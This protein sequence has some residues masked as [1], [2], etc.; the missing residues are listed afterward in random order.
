MTGAYRNPQLLASSHRVEEF[1][2]RSSEQTTWL[3]RY[4][5]QSA[6]AG[7]T[8]VFVVTS[9]T[10]PEVVAYYA[11]RM[12]Q[13]DVGALPERLRKGAGGH[14]QPVALLARLGVHVSHERQ[15]LGPALLSD[16]IRR[17]LA[18]SADIG[19]RGL[20]IHAETSEAR[21]FYQHLIPGLIGTPTDDLHLVL[22]IKDARKT[23]IR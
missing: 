12:A 14:P 22:L 17:L 4:A 20:L 21:E 6:A 5:R 16:A 7:L 9:G 10:E 18:L 1:V 3:R 8:K 11:W 15:G 13:L 2:C 23:L 19:C